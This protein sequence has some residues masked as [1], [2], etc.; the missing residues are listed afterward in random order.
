M[1]LHTILLLADVATAPSIRTYHCALNW[2]LT[3]LVVPPVLLNKPCCVVVPPY[4]LT[5]LLEPPVLLSK[6][7]VPPVILDNMEI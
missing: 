6:L 5:S 7:V 3:S 1:L 2:H 4:S